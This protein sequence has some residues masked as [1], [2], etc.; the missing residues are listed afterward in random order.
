MKRTLIISLLVAAMGIMMLSGCKKDEPI[1]QSDSTILQFPSRTDYLVES[2]S[3]F[4]DS[5]NYWNTVYEYDSLNH[6]IRRIMTGKI[7]EAYSTRD[8]TIV[9]D[10][11]YSDG[12]VSSI[13]SSDSNNSTY[14]NNFYY[15]S[16]GR[17][18]RAD[19]TCFSYHKGRMDRIYYYNGDPK[20][21]SALEYDAMGNIV[22]QTMHYPEY[23]DYGQQTTGKYL[24]RKYNFDYG[25]GIRPDFGLDYLFCY[26]PIPGQGDGLPPIIRLLSPNCMTTYSAGPEIW[27]YEYNEQGL[28]ITMYNQFA[29]VVP[30]NHPVYRFTYRHK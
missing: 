24:T 18:V 5:T 16:Y 22:L 29:D 1:D 30:I 15:D 27:E 4:D 8:Y 28:P 19:N 2:I 23:D 10:Y 17:L 7:F 12:K 20:V 11:I 14:T 3:W 9:S 26:E 21:Y 6:L 25:T 13:I